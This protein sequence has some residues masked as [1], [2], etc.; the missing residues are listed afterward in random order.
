MGLFSK[1]PELDD[2][3]DLPRVIPVQN[4]S[5]LPRAKAEVSVKPADPSMP[6]A[7]TIERHR[8]EQSE[9]TLLDQPSPV[10]MGAPVAPPA[11]HF[12]IADAVR[13]LRELPGKENVAVRAA[14]QRTLEFMSVDLG[15]LVDDG[16]VK[17]M[18]L[19]R[20]VGELSREVEQHEAL[21]LAAKKQIAA[22]QSERA[23]LEATKQWL[24]EHRR[25]QVSETVVERIRGNPTES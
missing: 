22:I 16:A 11:P 23:E 9:K 21:A 7:Q 6:P 13:L 12:N 14:V 20:R 2:D 5:A 10:V 1:R 8:P 24:L 3:E 19:E 25:G 18:E 15:R 17:D 4:K